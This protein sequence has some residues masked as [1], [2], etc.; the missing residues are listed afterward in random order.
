ML[1]WLMIHGVRVLK[2]LSR[3]AEDQKLTKENLKDAQMP[4]AE[5]S[6]SSSL[7]CSKC[8]NKKVRNTGTS[9]SD[10]TSTD[11]P[12]QVSYSQAQVRV[13]RIRRSACEGTDKI[14]YQTRSA[15]EPMVSLQVT[16]RTLAPR[17]TVT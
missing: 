10:K 4:M 6:I 12:I 2:R 17:L 3:R 15:D 13:I 7:E 8:K 1:P 5:R 14:C 9:H 16:G 11:M